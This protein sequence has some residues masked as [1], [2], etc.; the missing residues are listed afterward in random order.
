MS[1]RNVEICKRAFKALERFDVEA[2]LEHVDPEVVFQ[3]AIVSG[4]SGNTFRG[5]DGLRQWAAESDAAFAELRTVPEEFR[6]LGDDVLILGR[7]FA[8]GRESGV[9]LE[10]AAAFLCSLRDGRVVSVRGFLD[11][12]EALEAAGLRE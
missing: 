7:I 1:Q 6:D 4:A 9:P 12:E 5:H 8:R 3:S 2:A 10:S 11:R